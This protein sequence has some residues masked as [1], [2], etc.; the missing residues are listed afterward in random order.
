MY[1]HSWPTLNILIYK[2]VKGGSMDMT[3]AQDPKQPLAQRREIGKEKEMEIGKIRE[4]DDIV[5]S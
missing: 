5:F 3:A 4:I 2:G 1:G